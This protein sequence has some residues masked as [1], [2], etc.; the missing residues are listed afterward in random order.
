M[1]FFSLTLALKSWFSFSE[2]KPEKEWGMNMIMNTQQLQYLI[3]IERTR[4]ISQA[5]ANL[6]MGQPNLSRV[7]RDIESSIGFPIFERTRKGVRPTEKG[8]IFL[9]HAR[10]ILREADFMERM[11]SAVAQPNRFWVCLPRSYGCVEA[12]Q[13][14]LSQ[15]QSENGLDAVIRECHPRQAL[16]FLDSGYAEIAVIRYCVEYQDYISEQAAL[17]ELTLIPLNTTKF[18]IT[19][20]E[21]HPLAHRDRVLKADLQGYTELIHRDTFFPE[22]KGENLCRQIY[23]VDRMA[24]LQLLQ[25]MPG[26]YLWAEPIPPRMLRENRLVQLPCEDNTTRYQTTLA[27]KPQCALSEIEKGFLDHLTKTGTFLFG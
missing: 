14:Y 9:Q 20:S 3:E 17:K 24:Q 2:R 16:E 5:A 22:N 26:T 18:L 25:S 7:L 23:T 8:V 11:G 12:L 13:T 21:K 19:F 4:S 15:A 6:Y 10:N 27:Y 1:W